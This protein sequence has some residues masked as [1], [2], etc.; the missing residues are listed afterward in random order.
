V[1]ISDNCACTQELI[2]GDEVRILLLKL[3]QIRCFMSTG[4][5]HSGECSHKRVIEEFNEMIGDTYLI[6]DVEM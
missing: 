3:G 5:E 6:L 2:S 1:K 4:M